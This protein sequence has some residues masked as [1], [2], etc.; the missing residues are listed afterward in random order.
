MGTV[1]LFFNLSCAGL[2]VPD[3]QRPGRVLIAPDAWVAG[4]LDHHIV[5]EGPAEVDLLRIEMSP[6]EAYRLLGGTPIREIANT[7]LPMEE[8]LGRWA[9]E[10]L[11]R[12]HDIKDHRDRARCLRAALAARLSDAPGPDPAVLHIWQRIRAS[13]G[14]VQIGELAAEMGWTRRHLTRKFT[15]HA[16]L[17]PKSMARIRRLHLALDLLATGSGMAMSDLAVQCGYS[18]QPHL[19]RE[20]RALTGRTP[21]HLLPDLIDRREDEDELG[22]SHSFKTSPAPGNYIRP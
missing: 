21:S 7:D 6:W 11:Y 3:P 18:D 15:Q 10:M 5:T 14:R 2:K 19:T 16:G 12:L 4:P 1:S 9:T 20:M 13:G 17:P 22:T 8:F